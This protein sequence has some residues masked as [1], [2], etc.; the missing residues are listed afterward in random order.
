MAVIPVSSR[1][2]QRPLL[3]SPVLVKT[4]FVPLFPASATPSSTRKRCLVR[5]TSVHSAATH[6]LALLS[7]L[8]R[9]RLA[10]RHRLARGGREGE[11]GS[12]SQGQWSAVLPQYRRWSS[13]GGG[14]TFGGGGSRWIGRKVVRPR[15]RACHE[16]RRRVGKRVRA[17]LE[18]SY[19]VEEG[20]VCVVGR[21]EQVGLGGWM[22]MYMNDPPSMCNTK[23]R[24]LHTIAQ[25]GD[26]QFSSMRHSHC[27]APTP[28]ERRAYNRNV[29]IT[30]G[31]QQQH[32]LRRSSAAKRDPTS[33]R[34]GDMICMTK[35]RKVG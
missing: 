4:I 21:R 28:Q 8:I 26:A 14:A 34:T 11:V 32:P 22:G 29:Q 24:S 5:I 6:G 20:A 25:R 1:T 23:R 19:E 15:R 12:R 10:F 17:H 2:Q 33:R 31:F 13:R 27:A 30:A 35:M 7:K 18:E 9:L 3:A 16:G